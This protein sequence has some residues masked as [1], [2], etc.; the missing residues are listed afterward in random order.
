MGEM[1]IAAQ[2]SPMIPIPG[3]FSSVHLGVLIAGLVCLVVF[4]LFVAMLIVMAAS[5]RRRED[6]T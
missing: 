5:G 4:F 6:E 2:N 3:T 1:W